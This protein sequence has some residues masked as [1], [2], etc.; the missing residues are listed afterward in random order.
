V[1]YD[2]AEVDAFLVDLAFALDTHTEMVP[3]DITNVNFTRSRFGPG[4]Q[5]SEVDAFLKRTRRA[6]L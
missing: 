4:Y 1:G 3:A 2:I 6:L 5:K